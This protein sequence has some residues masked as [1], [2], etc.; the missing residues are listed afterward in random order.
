MPIS[1][2]IENAVIRFQG[3]ERES[4]EPIKWMTLETGRFQFWFQ[5]AEAMSPNKIDHSVRIL[6]FGWRDEYKAASRA[7][8]TSQSANE[9]KAFI[10]SYYSGPTL[11]RI[12]G[13]YSRENWVTTVRFDPGWILISDSI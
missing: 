13:D 6:S 10:T 2:A 9:I 11:K 4:L 7:V 12:S 8:F 1:L 5:V 3:F